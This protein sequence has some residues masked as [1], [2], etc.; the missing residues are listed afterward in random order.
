MRGYGS[1]RLE[2]EQV[3]GARLQNAQAAMELF[4]PERELDILKTLQMLRGGEQEMSQR[5]D[6][7]PLAQEAMKA[8]TLQRYLSSLFGQGPAQEQIMQ[9]FGLPYTNPM[10]QE[11]STPPP[12][13]YD[14]M[15][16]AGID[17]SI[18]SR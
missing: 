17:P 18:F 1:P 16:N 5:A 4:S 10:Q 15:I 11:S 12:A 6:M 14:K 8:E 9:Q 13:A 2:R 7:Q 3:R